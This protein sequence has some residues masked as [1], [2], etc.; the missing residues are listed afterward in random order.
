MPDNRKYQVTLDNSILG[1]M[2][3]LYYSEYFT[4]RLY[5]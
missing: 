1:N 4:F 3:T 5:S 2:P